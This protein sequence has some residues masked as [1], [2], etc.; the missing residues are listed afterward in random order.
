MPAVP[1]INT[2][3]TMAQEAAETPQ[4]YSSVFNSSVPQRPVAG[5]AARSYGGRPLGPHT[6]DPAPPGWPMPYWL[7]EIDRQG[8]SF[9]SKTRQRG[10]AVGGGR[11]AASITTQIDMLPNVVGENEKGVLPAAELVKKQVS[12]PPGNEGFTW[13]RQPQHPP[14]YKDKP[15]D[16]YYVTED[17]KYGKP[18]MLYV[19][20]HS[21]RKY[22]ASFNSQDRR[23]KELDALAKADNQLGPG[24]YDMPPTIGVKDPK[25]M[26]YPFKSATDPRSLK[27]IKDE[28]PSTVT[29]ALFARQ[30]RAWTSKG[31]AFSTRERFPR[32]RKRW[33]D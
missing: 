5:A 27:D 31:Y 10:G 12:N 30:A 8:P 6:Y 16:K 29:D 21:D 23:F 22:A 25:R 28:A 33:K 4:S 9:I 3:K 11:E 19:M 32:V 1:A 15:L 24:T 13:G 26:T 18:T 2:G 14:E 17:K 20:E 7:K